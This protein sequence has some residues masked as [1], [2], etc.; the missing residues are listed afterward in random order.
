[1]G[2]GLRD[3]D[4]PASVEELCDHCFARCKNLSGVRFS[5]SC[6]LK[7]I[8]KSPFQESGLRDVQVPDTVQGLL[9]DGFSLQEPCP[10]TSH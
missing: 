9:T 1:M 4:I 6:S 3:I 8:S 2:S 10:Y 5:E 7:H